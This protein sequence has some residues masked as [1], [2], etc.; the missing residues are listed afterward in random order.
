MKAVVRTKS[1]RILART[2]LVLPLSIPRLLI[3]NR[4]MYRRTPL[5]LVPALL[6]H[7]HQK[8]LFRI[9][10]R[11]IHVPFR[12]LSPNRPPFQKPPS[13]PR[14]SQPPSPRFQNRGYSSVRPS[15]RSC[16]QNWRQ[17]LPRIPRSRRTP[18]FP[19][20]LRAFPS[21]TPRFLTCWRVASPAGNRL[22]RRPISRST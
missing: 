1:K 2:I 8:S 11:R 14:P 6:S 16:R 18:P 7:H 17:L 5:L 21:K 9:P 4:T 20:P 13:P 3:Q 15:S 10:N 19:P 12:F 22:P